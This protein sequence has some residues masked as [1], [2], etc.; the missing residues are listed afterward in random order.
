MYVESG[1]EEADLEEGSLIAYG[2][3]VRIVGLLELISVIV[4][5]SVPRSMSFDPDRAETEILSCN[6]RPFETSF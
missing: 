1:V 3:R 6:C 4:V 5:G 2:D